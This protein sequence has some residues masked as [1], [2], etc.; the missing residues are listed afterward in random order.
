MKV[1]PVAAATKVRSLDTPKRS[2]AAAASPTPSSSPPS[3]VFSK[4]VGRDSNTF[5]C[6]VPVRVAAA[7]GVRSRP[8]S[9][10]VVQRTQAGEL[11][12]VLA[13]L[14]VGE[15]RS[16]PRIPIRVRAY[17]EDSKPDN[18]EITEIS[19]SSNASRRKNPV[20]GRSELVRPLKSCLRSGGSTDRSAAEASCTPK[21]V[22]WDDSDP[23]VFEVPYWSNTASSCRHFGTPAGNRA[24]CREWTCG[25]G[26]G[27]FEDPKRISPGHTFKQWCVSQ[28]GRG[29][30]YVAGGGLTDMYLSDDAGDPVCW[31]F[32][33]G[34]PCHESRLG[35]GKM[36]RW[37][38]F[39]E[40]QVAAE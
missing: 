31:A 4:V 7:V 2:S 27:A 21:T 10:V 38:L 36:E 22:H 32:T 37:R 20:T 6:R 5:R 40:A 25:I 19:N 18:T 8:A 30:I 1:R 28:R 35:P 15:K 33:L 9:E 11:K 26:N 34:H 12:V 24:G 23:P 16:S 39:E 17:T 3:S 13:P 14:P 29:H